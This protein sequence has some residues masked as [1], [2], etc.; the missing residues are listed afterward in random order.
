MLSA[1]EYS[2][3]GNFIRKDGIAEHN[4]LLRRSQDDAALKLHKVFVDDMKAAEATIAQ[5]NAGNS[6][7]RS[8]ASA[9]LPYNY[10]VPSSPELPA[11]YP[12]IT[13]RGIPYSISI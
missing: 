12:N 1:Y 2:Q 7:A 5:R 9:G 8:L 10:L 3:C 13:G 11:G 4:T 6:L